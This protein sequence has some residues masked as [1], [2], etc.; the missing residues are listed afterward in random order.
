MRNYIQKLK[1][2]FRNEYRQHTEAYKALCIIGVATL[3]I[4]NGV[5]FG[6]TISNSNYLYNFEPWIHIQDKP[7]D[8][9]N[10]VLSDMVDGNVS[11]YFMVEQMRNGDIPLWNFSE[12]LG[13][14]GVTNLLH[15]FHY[16]IRTIPWLLF[17]VPIGWT[18]EVLLKFILGGFFTYLFLK[19]LKVSHYIALAVS[20]GYIFSA[21]NIAAHIDGFATVP[22][23][24]PI[25][26]YFLERVFQDQNWKSTFGFMLSCVL[27]L[28][29][30]F[31]SII[32]FFGY[33]IILYAL[34]RFLLLPRQQKPKVLLQLAIAGIFTIGIASVSLLP[35]AEYL[36]N[37][38]GINL[39]YRQN[40]GLRQNHVTGLLGLFFANYMGHPIREAVLWTKGSYYNLSI[41]IGTIPLFGA[42]VGGLWRAIKKRDFAIL[43]FLGSS[44][45]LLLEV[46][47][48]PF[49]K[50]EKL[51]SLLP[52]FSHNPAM[53]QK[54][55]L[56]FMLTITGGLGLQYLFDQKLIMKK[57]K[58]KVTLGLQILFILGMTIS[59]Y[60]LLK[61]QSESVYLSGYFIQSVAL[62]T[63]GMLL[64]YLGMRKELLFKRVRSF[65]QAFINRKSFNDKN[66][67]SRYV[68]LI[69]K[70]LVGVA[71]LESLI[72]SA[73]WVP[74]SKPRFWLP[75]TETTNFL[76]A[77]IGPGRVVGIGSAAIPATIESYGIPT[78]AGRLSIPNAYKELLQNAWPG[79]YANHPTQSIIKT[80]DEIDMSHKVWDLIDVRYFVA[81]KEQTLDF[82]SEY[83]EDTFTIQRL[84]DST[85]IERN[86][87]NLHAFFVEDGIVFENDSDMASEYNKGSWDNGTHVMFNSQ[88][89]LLPG[90]TPKMDIST[91][92]ETN[93]NAITNYY[94]DTNHI[95][96]NF[97]TPTAGYV[98]ISSNYYP[99]WNAKLNGDE[100][101]IIPAY[102]F[103]KAIQVAEPGEYLLEMNYFPESLRLG[104]MIS[105]VSVSLAAVLFFILIRKERA[106]TNS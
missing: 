81:P 79:A 71:I 36:F 1:K 106:I 10:P 91:S 38:T 31:I 88:S 19:R 50:I 103:L 63:L 51:T 92:E 27:L 47:S 97:E 67:F 77:N 25:V 49:E 22:L 41:F 102:G 53:Y 52:I 6:K 74:Y 39:E 75:E 42:I 68:S 101:D 90:D 20:L 37:E 84:S 89:Y 86:S 44:L 43:F 62:A 3:L 4:F 78:A 65:C 85:I 58:H 82:L 30:R 9:G 57:W 70:L 61:Q 24:A 73:G 66:G 11:R 87:K 21:S 15:F 72:H 96:L 28:T 55:V 12:K 100:V 54:V 95:S 46:Y 5:L 16:P 18:I 26:F 35:T 76:E 33:W 48:L 98:V 14:P 69:G 29:T 59:A 60:Y 104:L 99:G 7:I 45:F 93:A 83:D 13:G 64:I 2:K 8:R 17:G 105:I 32:F 94:Q 34:I 40:F 80:V 56:Q 23:T